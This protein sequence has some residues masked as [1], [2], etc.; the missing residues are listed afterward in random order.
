MC[1]QLLHKSLL[2]HHLQSLKDHVFGE[3][4]AALSPSSE[5]SNIN[6]QL[7]L[8]DGSIELT[9]KILDDLTGVFFE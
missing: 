1:R 4:F 2:Y 3:L 5:P 7:I 9:I 6:D 8:L